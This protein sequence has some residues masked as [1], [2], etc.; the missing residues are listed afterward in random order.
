MKQFECVIKNEQGLHAMPASILAKTAKGYKSSIVLFR[1]DEKADMKNLFQVMEMCIKKD[2][3]IRI[4]ISGADEEPAMRKIM[5][6]M[7]DL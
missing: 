7:K 3:R 4:E 6:R 1:G 2:T 5:E